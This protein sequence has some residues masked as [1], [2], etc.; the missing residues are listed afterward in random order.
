MYLKYKSHGLCRGFCNKKKRGKNEKMR[1]SNLS[2]YIIPRKYE[3]RKQEIIKI[4]L[5]LPVSEIEKYK[6]FELFM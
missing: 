5:S 4:V 3:E 1:K 2:T 6:H